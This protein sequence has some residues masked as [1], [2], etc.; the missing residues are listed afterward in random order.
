[1]SW[2]TVAPIAQR[3][4]AVLTNALVYTTPLEL[5]NQNQVTA[6]VDF[7]LGSLTNMLL[8]VQMS[9]DKT[10]WYDYE[11]DDSQNE[12]VSGAD[13]D[14]PARALVR[15]FDA[16]CH[17]AIQIP[18]KTVWMRFGVI[19]TGTVTNSSCAISAMVGKA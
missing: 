5:V 13:A 11:I 10:N 14:I 16:D 2:L 7:T 12:A 17:L 3:T 6:L 4:A 1:M 9:P 15:L 19:G 18:V 8:R